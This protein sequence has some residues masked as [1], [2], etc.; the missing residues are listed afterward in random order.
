MLRNLSDLGYDRRDIG[1]AVRQQRLARNLTQ[2]E[3][4]WNAG[5]TQAAL[6]NYE[7]GKRDIPIPALISICRALGTYP[8]AVVPGLAPPPGE[9]AESL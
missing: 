2:A 6:S 7:N 3:V 5:I 4:A 8:V 1:E 9:G